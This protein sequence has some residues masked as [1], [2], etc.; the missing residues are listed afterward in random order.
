MHVREVY[1][2]VSSLKELI[3]FVKYPCECFKFA[4]GKDKRKLKINDICIY[5]V[6]KFREREGESNTYHKV[7]MN[8]PPNYLM[9]RDDIIFS[10]SENC[11]Q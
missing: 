10:N 9:L 1:K 3:F 4:E 2:N 7:R 11:D 6:V 8:A 5:T